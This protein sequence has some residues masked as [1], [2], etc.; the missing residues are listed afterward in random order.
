MVGQTQMV[1]VTTWLACTARQKFDM[2]C[3]W[4]GSIFKLEVRPLAST[5]YHYSTLGFRSIA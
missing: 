4:L 1:V 5:A 3:C 2:F